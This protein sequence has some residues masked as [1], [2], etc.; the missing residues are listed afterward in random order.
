MRLFPFDP[1]DS[2]AMRMPLRWLQGERRV[3][4]ARR[5]SYLATIC[6]VG[7]VFL[8]SHADRGAAMSL[9]GEIVLAIL[10][11]NLALVLWEAHELSVGLEEAGLE[12]TSPPQL[13]LA[14]SIRRLVVVLVIM[15]VAGTSLMAW[16]YQLLP[17]DAS[18]QFA[19][20]FWIILASGFSLSIYVTELITHLIHAFEIAL[21]QVTADDNPLN[22]AIK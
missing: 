22:Q 15:I 7:I 12:K 14:K 17:Q 21:V 10:I 6:G 2:L 4:W 20:M 9:A 19:L 16:A 11:A 3:R 8:V 1:N 5:I 18:G 13:K